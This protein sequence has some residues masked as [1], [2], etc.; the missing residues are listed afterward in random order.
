MCAATRTEQHRGGAAT[1]PTRTH[2][3]RTRTLWPSRCLNRFMLALLRV[4]LAPTCTGHLML[5]TFAHGALH[6]PCRSPWCCAD[7]TSRRTGTGH[8]G[9][10]VSF[11][12][13][14]VRWSPQV[15]PLATYGA[16][17][18]PLPSRP[19]YA[20]PAGRVGEAVDGELS[21]AAVAPYRAATP[22]PADFN[23]GQVPRLG[24]G[25][26]APRS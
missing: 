9:V 26:V 13:L 8:T 7:G 11:R 24:I 19:L 16:H 5:T 1:P 22:R 18:S 4:R 10:P 15:A 2:A 20:S 6:R 3:L 14:R 17:G 21:A 12:A 23:L 25:R